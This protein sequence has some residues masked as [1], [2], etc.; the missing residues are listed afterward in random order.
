MSSRRLRPMT[1]ADRER[2]PQPCGDHCAFSGGPC[3]FW[4]TSSSDGK[5]PVRPADPKARECDGVQ[6]VIERWGHCG[7]VAVVEGELIGYLTM[8]PADLVDRP[9]L[10]PA[11]VGADTAVLLNVYVMPFWRGQ[12]LGRQLVQTAAGQLVRA[13]VRV[14]DAVGTFREGPACKLAAPWLEAVGFRLVRAHPV[15][16]RF[17]MELQNTVRWRPG[18][19][20][21]WQ[22]LAGL[23][24]P[25]APEPASY[26]GRRESA[27]PALGPPTVLGVH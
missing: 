25:A 18:L 13:D 11:P 20:A 12:G 22:R 19:G 1:A 21:A 2:L 6:P 9:E 3:G 26:V 5:I 15:T 10:F 4:P 17:R 27:Q 14:F 23:V 24:V 7:V 8:A 16:P